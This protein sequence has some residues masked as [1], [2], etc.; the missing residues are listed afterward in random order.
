M[1]DN[2]LTIEIGSRLDSSFGSAFQSASKKITGLNK[3]LVEL[4]KKQ[5]TVRKFDMDTASVE[6]A[7]VKLQDAQK[8]VMQ[9]KLAA[10][11][12]PTANLGK[13]LEQA[14][15]KA[16]KLAVSL[17][18]QR[19][20]LQGSTAAMKAAGL[21]T[22]NTTDLYHRL[23]E[24]ADQVAQKLKKKNV[25]IERSEQRSKK[26][27]SALGLVKT[28]AL[29]AGAAILGASAYI[30]SSTSDLMALNKELENA[31]N[32]LGISSQTL[33]VWGLGAE[34]VG[35][36]SEKMR[37]IFKDVSDKLGDLATTGGG[38][39]KDVIERLGLSIDDLINK[40]PD[41]AI[42]DIAQAMEK[43]SNVSQH[44]KIFLMEALADEGSALLPLLENNA[45]ALRDIE[46]AAQRRGVIITPEE[47]KIL[48]ASN[49]QL[50][51][52][53]MAMSGLSQEAGLLGAEMFTALGPSVTG[54]IDD[55]IVGV[56]DFRSDAALMGE[57]WSESLDGMGGKTQWFSGMAGAVWSELYDSARMLFT[58]LPVVAEA[59]YTA[60][61]AYG[62][63]WMHSAM[64]SWEQF[65]ALTGSTM[66]YIVDYGGIAF[67]ALTDIAGAAV[68][69][70][71][72]GWADMIGGMAWIAD[73][74]GLDDVSAKL[75]GVSGNIDEVAT[76]AKNSGAVVRASFKSQADSMRLSAMASLDNAEAHKAAAGGAKLAAQAAIDNAAAYI[77]RKESQREVNKQ[78][79]EENAALGGLTSVLDSSSS[80]VGNFTSHAEKQEK[81]KK[82]N[83]AA[84]KKAAQAEKELEKA[85]KATA[86]AIQRNRDE[87][88]TARDAVEM[89]SIELYEG[90]EAALLK[91]HAVVGLTEA[92]VKE[93][94]A[95][96]QQKE[97]LQEQIQLR[98]KVADALKE[99]HDALKLATIEWKKGADAAK[100]AA[101]KLDGFSESEAKAKMALDKETEALRKN[102]ENRQK[103]SDAIKA[104]RNALKLATIEWKKGADAAK[105]AALKLDGFSESEAKA[106]RALD[107]ET[108]ALRKNIENRQKAKDAIQASRNALKLATIEWTK[109]ADAAKVAAL[110]LDGFSE[111][112]AK[113]KVAID[114][115]TES[116]RENI[117]NRKKATEA[118]AALAE[119]LEYEKIKLTQGSEAAELYRLKTEGYTEAL[120]LSQIE[121]EKNIELLQKQGELANT[122]NNGLTDSIMSAVKT[123]KLSFDSLEDHL[124]QTFNNMILKPMVQA[125][126]KPVSNGIASSFGGMGNNI[127]Q[128]LGLGK[129]FGQEG[130]GL[131]SPGG[132][133]GTGGKLGGISNF[134]GGLS[135]GATS[136]VTKIFGSTGLGGTL[137]SAAGFLAP[138]GLI[139]GAV[140]LIKSLFKKEKVPTI[141]FE[142]NKIAG[143]YEAGTTE[144]TSAF[145]TFGISDKDTAYSDSSK[146]EQYLDTLE[147]LDNTLASFL[148][149]STVDR[150]KDTL[151]G[152]TGSM[153]EPME[154][155]KDRTRRIYSELSTGIKQ[156][157]QGVD[158]ELFKKDME[159]I[160]ARIELVG[161]TAA[162]VSPLVN[163]LGL[164]MSSQWDLAL[165]DTV[166]LT[167]AM[168]GVQQAT[169]GLS[170][171]YDNLV[172]PTEKFS[173]NFTA[174]RQTLIDL[175]AAAGNTN[176][177]LITTKQGLLDYI[178]GLDLSVAKNAELAA[179]AISAAGAMGTFA[180]AIQGIKDMFSTTISQIENDL[181]TQQ[182][183]QQKY[184]REAES[185]FEQLKAESD[186][187]K[188]A[189]MS[190]KINA[191]VQNA[192]SNM[193]AEQKSANADYLKTMLQASSDLASEQMKGAMSNAELMKSAISSMDKPV[194]GITSAASTMTGA[195][196][197]M[198]RAASGMNSAASA[199]ASAASAIPR[200]IDVNVST[201]VTV[202][203]PA[204]GSHA[205]GLTNVPFDGYRAILHKKELVATAQESELLRSGL[206]VM[207]DAAQNIIPANLGMLLTAANDGPHQATPKLPKNVS[208]LKQKADVVLKRAQANRQPNNITV[209]GDTIT[210]QIKQAPGQSA[211]DVERAVQQL[212]KQRDAKKARKIRGLH[213][214]VG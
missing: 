172:S 55:M 37:D 5:Q 43:V 207:M 107:K 194:A 19:G 114:K 182:E 101:L 7:R 78:I 28:G 69:A 95:L 167:D 117:A 99:S 48:N 123:G 86:D 8:A 186:P 97:S 121:H 72:A 203:N 40:K 151:H 34:R 71:I 200:T 155:M 104:S 75:N 16:E 51:D 145:G 165:R 214:D 70:I 58:Y 181:L 170:L 103:A 163:A 56:R 30:S 210:I 201:N 202:N 94:V 153:M 23:G 64:A 158:G 154:M 67:G 54:F 132:L 11:K 76:A 177:T 15:R 108:E 147:L 109:G 98:E 74:V 168:G 60:V 90:K 77:D 116:L 204:D 14:Q 141:A 184:M 32:Q 105:V 6:K 173:T 44:D 149:E 136:A 148:P 35:L 29:A 111:S 174:A 211:K 25:A 89:L 133:L 146:T 159:D 3:E 119:R 59:G 134:F 178:Q 102:I 57:V 183:K 176:G 205:N 31:E 131:F 62:E 171:V 137:G 150:I 118:V 126:M 113:A 18:K 209:E 36:S 79:R 80:A 185:L 49:A 38:E 195:A 33:Q 175:N 169:A 13:K 189:E 127:S 124:K 144:H 96:E 53:K 22:K 197:G 73:A 190:E 208:P 193:T 85:N 12:D 179:Q 196:S 180:G 82:A 128:S 213:V 135:T 39:A 93:R 2:K 24:E 9:L 52:M 188:I 110:K 50:A 160:A 41:Q 92:E 199:M 27:S 166:R 47:E 112:E 212:F 156:A 42:M 129:M 63:N 20:K 17:E 46:D 88:E 65:K 66:A 91:K 21:S 26:L 187:G 45:Q 81:T 206:P 122:L 4:K 143:G 84:S 191:A 157:L 161:A 100:V 87:L 115:E 162:Q 68:G 83:A 192:W 130:P 139:A 125:V 142:N 152:Y 106:K 1:A 164:K 120:A 61:L 198:D 140:G 138:V 10:S